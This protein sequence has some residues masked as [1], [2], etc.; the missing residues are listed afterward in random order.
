[1]ESMLAYI[2]N[3]NKSKFENIK[4]MMNDAIIR[5]KGKWYRT[6]NRYR[7]DLDLTWRELLEMDKNTLKNVSISMIMTYGN[8]A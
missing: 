2:V 5:K 7:E 1:M 4:K 3:V 8:K 6:V